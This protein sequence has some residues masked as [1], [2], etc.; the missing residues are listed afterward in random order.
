[1][2]GHR[3]RTRGLRFVGSVLSPVVSS[4][5]QE[6]TPYLALGF[7]IIKPPLKNAPKF[8]KEEGKSLYMMEIAF[9]KGIRKPN[10]SQC[11]ALGMLKPLGPNLNYMVSYK[12]EPQEKL[13]SGSK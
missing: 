8:G 1:M 3:Q 2:W 7:F 5:I 10:S 13:S 12:P 4:I 9:L 6:V 11:Q